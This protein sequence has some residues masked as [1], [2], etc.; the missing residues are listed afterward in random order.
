MA[1][2]MK[3]VPLSV[4]LILLLVPSAW[5]QVITGV[6]SSDDDPVPMATV[7]VLGSSR[8][9][10]ADDEGRYTLTLSEAGAYTLAFSAI[11]FQTIE[12]EATVA[13]GETLEIDVVLS[14]TVYDA[15]T[16]VVTGTMTEVGARE[17]PVKVEVVPQRFLETAPTASVAE[18][19]QRING[20][21]Q[22][23]DCGVCY[24]SSIRINGIE[25]P[26][27]AFLID[28]MPIMSSLAAVYGFDSISPVLVRQMEIVKGPMSTLYG[29]E[30]LG[31]VVNIITKDPSTAPT[32]SV[33]AFR[34]HDGETLAEVAAV[35]FRG[36]YSA[37]VSA[38]GFQFGGFDD[39]NRDGF[40]DHVNASRLSV[41]G[42]LTAT[43]TRGFE[44]AS[45]V[46]RGY[47]ED[48]F[49]G[50]EAFI[51]DPSGLRGSS[52][53]YG[54]SIRTRRG[55]LLGRWHAA[56]GLEMQGAASLHYQ[57]SYYGEAYYDAIQNTAFVQA[58]FTPN[59]SNS[60]WRNHDV[61]V[62]AAMRAQRYDD[63]S[64]ATGRYD[65]TGL[66][67]ANEPDDRIVPGVFVQNDWSAAEGLRLLGGFRV[68]YQPDHG[69]VPSPRV[70]LKWQPS[71]YTTLR[72]NTGTGFRLVNL[73][74]ED[75]QAYSGG[76]ATVILEDLAP[77]RSVSVSSSGQHIFADLGGLTVD[78]DAFWTRFS[79]KI[80]PDYATL[81]EI[82]YRNLD[83]FAVTRG[84]SAQVQGGPS[85]LRFTLGATLLDVFVEEAGQQ[86]PLEYAPDYQANATI[87][88]NAPGGLT[89]DY[90][91]RLTGPVAL[92]R[93]DA[94]TRTAYQAATGLPLRDRSPAYMIHHIQLS[95]MFTLQDG[96]MLQAYFGVENAGD[97]TQGSPLIGYYD[98]VP[99]FSD[100]FDTTYAYGPIVGRHFGLGARLFLP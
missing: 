81:G 45:V 56:L 48:R 3:Y 73:F 71:Y 37:L 8:G 10:A 64:G 67:L 80:E 78:V 88:W 68:D 15:G 40:S 99:G 62:G 54:E 60:A 77:E 32:L 19:V 21:T 100:T 84:L 97:Y 83:G 9:T 91:A 93:F 92:P 43:D 86:R 27:T 47:F 28:G 50:V 41:F 58:L 65:D 53:I 36:R 98:G 4:L 5:A 38:T 95:R 76:R 17:S 75:H 2:D 25:G 31:G 79:N 70:A 22:Q 29:S 34:T 51:A 90:S 18:A 33:N 14:S 39:R 1:V 59:L 52:D 72:L 63:N 49:N 35:P 87:T 89:L 20:L 69:V 24:T 82:R 85:A 42:K 11:G 30:A 55:E 23:V 96:R 74:T 66:L 44:Q 94:A 57:D 26:N 61:L 6:V 7:R 12:R 16:L 46:A 13:S